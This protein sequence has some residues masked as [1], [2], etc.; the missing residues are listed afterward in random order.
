[1]FKMWKWVL[2]F[3]A[4]AGLACGAENKGDY[5]HITQDSVSLDLD[6]GDLSFNDESVSRKALEEQLQQSYS[7]ALGAV[8][9]S[10]DPSVVSSSNLLSVLEMIDRTGMDPKLVR[11]QLYLPPK[12]KRNQYHQ[13]ELGRGGTVVRDGIEIAV[14]DLAAKQLTGT[15]FVI[16]PKSKAMEADYRQF[17]AVLRAIGGHAELAGLNF[18]ETGRIEVEANIYQLQADGSH[19]VLS[20]PK[21]TAKPGSSST[22]RAVQNATGR[23]T[24]Q[25]WMDEF[26]QEDLANLGIRFTARPQ[27]IG[28][29]LRVSGVAIMTKSTGQAGVFLQDN[30][31]VCS[32]SCSKM[33][34][35]FSMV[36]PPGIEAL[37]FSVAKVDGEETMCRLT[38]VVVDDR[39]MTRKQREQA[40]AAAR[41]N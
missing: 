39:G 23:S 25:P 2:V 4:V 29:H 20:A 34:V 19:D 40:R 12:L 5:A 26:H 31:P 33:V 38:A 41:Q 11:L 10:G 21:L 1:M 15:P 36:F 24:Y 13:I 3:V 32:Y 7:V 22:I 35:P 37:E 8:S 14:T 27:I 9:F 16:D 18:V 17:L 6:T 30:V 28:D